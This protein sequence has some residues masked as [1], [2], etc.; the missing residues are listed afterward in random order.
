MNGDKVRKVWPVDYGDPN[1]DRGIR[2]PRCGC[3]RSRVFYTRD[4]VGGR[5]IRRRDCEACGRRY[6]TYER[7]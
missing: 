3:P 5:R 7:T 6:T 1:D 4:S 2:C